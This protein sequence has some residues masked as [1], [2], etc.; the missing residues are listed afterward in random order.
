MKR[1]IRSNTASQMS[2]EELE[3]AIEN[4]FKKENIPYV[5]VECIDDDPIMIV[6][7]T[8]GDWKNDNDRADVLVKEAFNPTS[9]DYEDKDPYDYL[10]DELADRF[11]GSDNCVTK[12]EY[13]WE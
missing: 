10:D 1:Y 2:G 5:Y 4:L 12:H 3:V 13:I 6:A 9:I 8:Y 7:I 11:Q